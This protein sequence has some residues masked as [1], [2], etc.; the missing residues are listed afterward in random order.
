MQSD[1]NLKIMLD[2]ED[3]IISKLPDLARL[4]TFYAVNRSKFL[5]GI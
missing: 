1:I 5:N 2:M 4:Q 3:N